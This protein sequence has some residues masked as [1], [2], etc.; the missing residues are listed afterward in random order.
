[1]TPCSLLIPQ[2][3]IIAWSSLLEV[4]D[5]ISGVTSQDLSHAHVNLLLSTNTMTLTRQ[6]DS[7]LTRRYKTVNPIKV[8]MN[9]DGFGNSDILLSLKGPVERS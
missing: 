3:A 6:S 4:I 2:P 1:M 9:V 8:N 5:T 7:P